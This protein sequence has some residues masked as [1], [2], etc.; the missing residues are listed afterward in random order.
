MNKSF[1]LLAF[2]AFFAFISASC[3]DHGA[4][5]LRSPAITTNQLLTTNQP[6]P[7]EVYFHLEFTDLGE[8]G[9]SEYGII[10]GNGIADADLNVGNSAVGYVIFTG[11][12]TIGDVEQ[13]KVLPK[14]V[15]PF[16][17]KAYAKLSDGSV[18]Y[19]QLQS[20]IHK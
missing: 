6:D 11:A 10:Y 16:H 2:V 8:I 15:E 12:P 13:M 18:I 4:E 19:G 3:T 1:R 17:Y 20:N 7:V 9:V 5:P 14:L